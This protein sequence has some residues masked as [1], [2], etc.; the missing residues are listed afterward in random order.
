MEEK[1]TP[2]NI[3]DLMGKVIIITGANNGIGFET[4]KTVAEKGAV[5]VMA[6]RNMKKA[7]T[8][9]DRIRRDV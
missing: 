4:A 6:C 7:T 8:A 9:A 5:V 2:A 3:P 1:W